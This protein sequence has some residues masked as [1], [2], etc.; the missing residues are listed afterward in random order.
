MKASP[1]GTLALLF[2]VLSGCGDNTV[3]TVEPNADSRTGEQSGRKSGKS[4]GAAQAD[5]GIK[6]IEEGMSEFEVLDIMGIP[7]KAR[8]DSETM[9]LGPLGTAKVFMYEGAEVWHRILIV[10]T[11]LKV[12]S[13]ENGSE[14]PQFPIRV[15]IMKTREGEFEYAFDSSAEPSTTNGRSALGRSGVLAASETSRENRPKGLKPLFKEAGVG[16][17]SAYRVISGSAEFT[18]GDVIVF[19]W[20]VYYA[21]GA[22]HYV[23]HVGNGSTT[24]E[25]IAEIGRS[26]RSAKVES[27]YSSS[28]VQEF[29]SGKIKERS[30]LASNRDWDRLRPDDYPDLW[31]HGSLGDIKLDLRGA[32]RILHDSNLRV[33]RSFF[34]LTSILLH[35]VLVDGT[36]RAMWQVPASARDE[37]V[38]YLAFVDA[39]TGVVYL[40]S[41]DGSTYSAEGEELDVVVRRF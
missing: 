7:D 18:A 9:Q 13:T 12:Y 35:R 20:F 28:T 34:G 29:S 6:K 21:A 4:Q 24:R 30:K 41:P 25:T 10:G 31:K 17:D 38:P 1:C 23:I 33:E 2:C 22:D 26:G 32:V 27:G 36:S 37:R 16:W 14:N 3:S 19:D 11:V 39:S 40:V 15:E 8:A 5:Q